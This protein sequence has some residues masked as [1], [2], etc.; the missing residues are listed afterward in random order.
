MS[1]KGSSNPTSAVPNVQPK[2]IAATVKE[3][4]EASGFDPVFLPAGREAGKLARP[5]LERPGLEE[6]AG[7]RRDGFNAGAK[8]DQPRMDAKTKA[9]VAIVGGGPAGVACIIWLYQL[10]VDAIFD[11]ERGAARRIAETQPLSE[12][13]GPGLQQYDGSGHCA[14]PMNMRKRPAVVSCST[15]KCSACVFPAA[16]SIWRY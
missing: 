2:T 6:V 12:F 10:G 9:Q 4:I 1:V 8:E 16:S 13:M 14:V 3:Y 7:R 11:R 15:A 5:G